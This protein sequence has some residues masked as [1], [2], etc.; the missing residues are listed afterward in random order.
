MASANLVEKEAAA[1]ACAQTNFPAAK[2]LLKNN[3]A[4]DSRV[5]DGSLSWESIAAKN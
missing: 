1:L 2:S 5:N 3:P 4:L